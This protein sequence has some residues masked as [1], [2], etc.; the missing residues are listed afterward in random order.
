[1]TQ[2][3]MQQNVCL[4]KTYNWTYGLNDKYGL[5]GWM[6]KGHFTVGWCVCKFKNLI[7]DCIHIKKIYSWNWYTPTSE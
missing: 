4:S 3:F 6:I 5:S 7:N 2:R 1:M